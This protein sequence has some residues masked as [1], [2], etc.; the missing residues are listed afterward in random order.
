MVEK[1]QRLERA[2]AE[3]EAMR[4][5]KLKY[6]KTFMLNAGHEVEFDGMLSTRRSDVQDTAS[7]PWF[8]PMKFMSA[9]TILTPRTQPVETAQS[10]ARLQMA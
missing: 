7:E 2:R 8:E 5:R 3:T 10:S 6:D 1:A 4:N 9:F